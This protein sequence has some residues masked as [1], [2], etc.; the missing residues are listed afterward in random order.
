MLAV[1]HSRRYE[2]VKSLV[3]KDSVLPRVGIEFL[4]KNNQEKV[5][6][7]KTSFFLNCKEKKQGLTLEK[8]S[9][10][11]PFSM[12]KKYSLIVIREGLSSDLVEKLVSF[13]SVKLL[14]ASEAGNYL[15][16]SDGKLKK[17]VL[18]GI[19][20]ILVCPEGESA[21]RFLEKKL[22]AKGMYPNK[23][24]S[25]LTGNILDE[26]K[27]AEAGEQTLK[28]DKN[29]NINVLLGVSSLSLD[30]L[31][32]N[33]SELYTSVISLRPSNWKG[34]FLKKVVLSTAMGP[35]VQVTI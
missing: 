7:I 12:G 15:I 16:S 27:K 35:G 32:R 17:R 23:K 26:V 13:S 21:I 1:I 2:N 3:F 24:N 22:I 20:K 28:V 6:K 29:G 10:L 19:R 33:Y 4:Q 8:K 31:M 25:W 14:S 5:K 9:L 11:L 34:L 18:K 30:E